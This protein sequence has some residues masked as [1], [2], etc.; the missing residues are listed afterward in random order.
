MTCLSAERQQIIIKKTLRAGEVT[1]DCRA[2]QK[3]TEKK[4]GALSDSKKKQKNGLRAREVTA[5]GKRRRD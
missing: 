4:N 1:G 3:A 2:L 5:Q